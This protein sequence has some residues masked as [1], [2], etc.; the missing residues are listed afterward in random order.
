MT[1]KDYEMV[2]K[3]INKQVAEARAFPGDVA[4]NDAAIDHLENLASDLAGEF[5]AA[6]PKFDTASFLKACGFAS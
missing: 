1:R 5:A 4:R 3:A 6:N 2:A